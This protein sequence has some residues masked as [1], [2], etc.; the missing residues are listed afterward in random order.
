[1]IYHTKLLTG[2]VPLGY[3]LLEPYLANDPPMALA[4]PGRVGLPAGQAGAQAAA[5]LAVP[6]GVPRDLAARHISIYYERNS[7]FTPD[8]R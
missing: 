2:S 6:R 4:H 8:S 5:E 3:H 7:F 1:L